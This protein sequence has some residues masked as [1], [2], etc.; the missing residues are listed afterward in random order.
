MQ[1][2]DRMAELVLGLGA[3]DVP[4]RA[5]EM[6][7]QAFVDAVGCA[8]AGASTPDAQISAGWVQA[9]GGAP[10]AGLIA[11]RGGAAPAALAALA[12][13]TAAHALDLD[14][15]SPAMNHPSV[16][17]VPALLA[18]GQ[19]EHASG[20]DVELAYVAGFEVTARVCRAINP[21]HYVRGWHSTST[22]GALGVAA[23]VAR[24][25]GLDRE[26][27]AVAVGIAASMAAGLRQ[28][29]GTMVKPLHAGTAAFQGVS[30]AELAARGFTADRHILDGPRGFFDVYRGETPA[31]V[32]DD[33]FAAGRLE[34]DESGIAFKR[35][36]CCGAIHTAIEATLALIERHDLR[37]ADVE[38]VDCRVNR[39]APDILIHHVADTPTQ[40]RFCVEYSVAAT[41]ID[42]DAGA[43][44]YTP[45]RVAD[46]AIQELSR[47]V[48][49]TVDE[50][51]PVGTSRSDPATFPA[52]VTVAT[53]SGERLTERSDIARGRPHDPFSWDELEA[54]FRACAA[55]ELD[56]AGAERALA[57][58]RALPELDDV[59][60][61]AAAFPAAQVAR[62]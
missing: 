58:L 5:M 20:A 61:I 45:E 32:S 24:L 18:V 49:V 27:V 35:F 52:V 10:E 50:G 15:F 12:N 56:E 3:G 21:A 34:L 40:A 39:L 19:R 55:L 17:L 16:C 9:M 7:R 13:G 2:T 28:N 43:A 47:R 59:G 41:L 14:D 54:K 31:Q 29:F 8:L 60:A 6:V 37:A 42:G 62:L 1:V 44:Q 30:A 46:P 57:A 48:R 38:A 4:P 53:R 11:A 22:A 23:G 25:L 26:R 33:T 51:L 36:A